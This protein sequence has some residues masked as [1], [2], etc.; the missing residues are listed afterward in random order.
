MALS[1]HTVEVGPRGIKRWV[2]TRRHGVRGAED[3]SE[4]RADRTVGAD[5][6]L[7]SRRPLLRLVPVLV[8]AGCTASPSERAHQRFFA[9]VKADPLFTWRPAWLSYDD[10]S[11]RSGNQGIST[12]GGAELTRTIGGTP[13][14]TTGLASAREAAL[15]AGWSESGKQVFTKSLLDSE[16]SLGAWASISTREDMSAVLLHV[17]SVI[18]EAVGR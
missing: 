18:P 5:G 17:I 11:E 3:M 14:P 4:A 9:A 15:A 10:L 8:F 2:T 7:F 13:V 16:G 1:D 6:R 12:D